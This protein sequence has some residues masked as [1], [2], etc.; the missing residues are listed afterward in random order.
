MARKF[1]THIDLNKLELQ[2]AVI[3]NLANPPQNPVVGQIYFDTTLQTLRT[4]TLVAETPAP[5]YDW[6]S[7]GQGLQGAQGAQ[8]ADGYVGSDGAQG[9]Q[10]ETGA[11]GATGADGAQG[12]Q[13]ANAGILSVSG[14]LSVDGAGDLTINQSGLESTLETN[15]FV[16]S[17]NGSISI[18]GGSGDLTV[19]A[20]ANIVLDAAS[21][22]AVYLDSATAGNEVVTTTALNNA[23]DGAALGSTDDLTEGVNNLYY[24][25]QRVGDYITN[26]GL[27]LQG[28][29]GIQGEAGYVG[30]DGAQGIQGE[31][32]A[33]GA[34]GSNA[35]I[36]SVNGPLTIGVQGDLGLAYGA[37]L[38]LASGTSLVVNTDNTLVTNAGIA[39]NQLGVDTTVIATKAYVDGVASGLDVKASVTKAT[40]G[41]IT[42]SGEGA[43]EDGQ[44]YWS[45]E[46]VLVKNQN[47]SSENG[48]YIVNKNGA[49]TKADDDA[50]ITSGSFTFVEQGTN[51]GHGFVYTSNYTWTQ[52]SDSSNY[53]TSVGANLSVV[54]N[55]LN[56]DLT[57]KAD[58]ADPTLSGTLTLNGSGDFTIDSDDNIVFQTTS[59]SNVY[60][61]SATSGN[62]VATEGYVDTAVTGM[63]KKYSGDINGDGATSSFELSHGLGSGDLNVIVRDSSGNVVET[64]VN[65]SSA[66]VTI[67]FAVAPLSGVSYRVTV[68]G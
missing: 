67:G 39:A 64:D 23:I 2:N 27:S 24:T 32:G 45:Q 48:I 55:Q 25:D 1:L 50:T 38:G 68:T 58:A 61:G 19:T 53:I 28:A 21:G 63:V 4:Y 44:S 52:F 47:T 7:S 42:L 15:G 34:Q 46:R 9:A 10:G 29:Q 31:T 60:I 40:T 57:S 20:D 16:K 6:I 65:I 17:T 56:V 59:P 54:N 51:A 35:G 11:Q 33:Q 30:S 41:N 62:E 49:W 43:L 8:G 36:L 18:P 12:I 22:H 5:S 3:Q 13:G 14:N 37:G 26:N 66:K